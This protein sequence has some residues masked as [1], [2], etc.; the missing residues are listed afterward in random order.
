[1]YP[2]CSDKKNLVLSESQP[3]S[4]NISFQFLL[5]KSMPHIEIQFFFKYKSQLFTNIIRSCR[6]V[7]ARGRHFVII[8]CIIVALRRTIAALRRIIPAL[9]SRPEHLDAAYPHIS[10]HRTYHILLHHIR[11][12]QRTVP[13]HFVARTRIF[14]RTIPRGIVAKRGSVTKR[15][16]VAKR[17]VQMR[18]GVQLQ[19]RCE[20]EEDTLTMNGWTPVVTSAVVRPP[21]QIAYILN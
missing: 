3:L 4:Q 16:L 8:P 17:G 6:S 20:S 11:T 1:M 12:F 15:D 14:R 2:F 13:V 19:S 5:F 7:V 10:S 21:R 18:N 9:R